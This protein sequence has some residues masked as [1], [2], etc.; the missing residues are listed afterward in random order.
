[1][2]RKSAAKPH[3]DVDRPKTWQDVDHLV[4]LAAKAEA[5]MT[6]AKADAD[7]EIQATGAG[8]Q[9]RLAPL[10][11]FREAVEEAVETFAS[12]HRKDF[13]RDRS[14]ELA[15]GRLGWRT[16]PPAV[17]FRRPTEE[18]VAGLEERGLDVAVMVTKRPAKDVLATFKADLLEELGVRVTQRD[19]FYVEFAE[20]QVSEAPAAASPK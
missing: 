5:E 20:A 1:M 7:K 6:V 15:H 16:S 2:P 3:P 10:A 9:K 14:M 13:G 18:I 11:A 19:L 4:H 8:L 17:T 12:A